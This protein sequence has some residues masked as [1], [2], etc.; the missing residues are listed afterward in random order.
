MSM[1]KKRRAP[2]DYLFVVGAVSVL[3]LGTCRRALADGARLD[4]GISR[5]LAISRAA[6]ISDVRYR[7]EFAL[8]PHANT[9]QGREV[10]AFTLKAEDNLADLPFDFRGALV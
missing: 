10:L 2:G 9:L 4:S 7:V 1:L 5:G 8:V 6:R 3:V